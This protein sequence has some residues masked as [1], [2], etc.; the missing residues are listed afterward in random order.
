MRGRIA[1]QI[2]GPVLDGMRAEVVL[3]LEEGDSN[4]GTESEL[5]RLVAMAAQQVGVSITEPPGLVASPRW[6][7]KTPPAEK[8]PPT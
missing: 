4:V 1:V 5:R 8:A 2:P 6:S 7:T 3:D